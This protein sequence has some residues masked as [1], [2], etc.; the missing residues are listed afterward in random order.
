MGKESSESER[1]S[2]LNT[3]NEYVKIASEQRNITVPLKDISSGMHFK[4]ETC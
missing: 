2:A 4:V 3:V 1:K